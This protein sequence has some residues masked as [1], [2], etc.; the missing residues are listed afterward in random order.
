MIDTCS[1]PE[2]RG[3]AVISVNSRFD[4]HPAVLAPLVGVG[5]LGLLFRNDLVDPGA[6]PSEALLESG[7]LL[8]PI[9]VLGPGFEAFLKSAG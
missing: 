2:E 8:L 5:A 6:D 1:G 3:K 9:E 7:D 4:L